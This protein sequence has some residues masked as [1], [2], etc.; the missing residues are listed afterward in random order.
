MKILFLSSYVDPGSGASILVRLAN[1][2][3]QE[4]HEV[5]ILTTCTGFDSGIIKSVCL[6]RGTGFINKVLNKVIPNYFNLIYFQLLVE[7]QAYNPDVISIHWTHGRKPIPIQLIP[8]LNQKYPVFWTIHDLWPITN[9]SF[10][11]FTECEALLKENKNN[12]KGLIRQIEFTPELLLRYKRTLLGSTD[13]HTIS[14]SKWLQEKINASPVFRSAANHHIPNG[15]DINVF[16]PL[17]QYKLKEKYGVPQKHKVILFLAANLADERKGFYYFAKALDCLRKTNPHLADN[18]TTLLI[19]ENGKGASEFL[20]TEVKNLG[21]TKDI[22]KLVEYY[23]VAD[24]FVSASLADNFPSTSLESLACGTPIV[25]FD[26]GGV[27]EIVIHN[28]TGLLSKSKNA[29]DLARNIG[30]ILTDKG[31]HSSLSMECRNYAINS[32][33]MEEF[34]NSYLELFQRSE[35]LRSSRTVELQV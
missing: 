34:L 35:E 1:R 22:S 24:V 33:S 32:F 9:N 5:R 20:P 8:K 13:L 14:P 23:N 11:E 15:V 19:G 31:L 16:R 26:V 2:L 27:S 28:K 17:E 12:L 25:A 10:F 3:K 29:G 21:S 4:G 7:I 30:K 6:P 18:I